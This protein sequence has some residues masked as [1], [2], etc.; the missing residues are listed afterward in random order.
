MNEE[1]D[2]TN[3]KCGGCA[4]NIQTGLMA[5]AGV[6]AV[7][8]EIASGHVTVSGEALLRASLEAKLAELG[9]PV[10]TA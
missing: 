1:F 5:M 10:K 3:V 9:Y 8:V 6:T 4:A 7:E 2:V